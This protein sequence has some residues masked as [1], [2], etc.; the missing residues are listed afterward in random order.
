V[1]ASGQRAMEDLHQTLVTRLVVPFHACTVKEG[2]KFWVVGLKLISLWSKSACKSDPSLLVRR[3][4]FP[5]TIV[6][7]I[8]FLSWVRDQSCAAYTGVGV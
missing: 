6:K 5:T 3:V 4:I 1:Q 8:Y 7:V 2:F